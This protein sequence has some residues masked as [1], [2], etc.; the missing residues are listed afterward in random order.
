VQ[1]GAPVSVGGGKPQGGS[2]AGPQAGQGDRRQ[3]GG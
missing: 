3:K 2:Q 1:D